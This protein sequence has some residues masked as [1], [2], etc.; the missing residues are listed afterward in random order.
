MLELAKKD[1]HDN[2]GDIIREQHRVI[3]LALLTTSWV[4]PTG[5]FPAQ[6]PPNA[7]IADPAADF[8]RG[9]IVTIPSQGF[10]MDAFFYL[11]S[12]P[13]R[14]LAVI[15][16]SVLNYFLNGGDFIS[17]PPVLDRSWNLSGTRAHQDLL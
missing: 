16:L 2:H 17:P 3:V 4:I 6:Q 8:R 15:A 9:S 14:Q 1:N 11:A 12:G 13:Q 5:L 10:E 7:V